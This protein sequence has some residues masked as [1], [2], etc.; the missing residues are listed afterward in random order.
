MNTFILSLFNNG[1][2]HMGL[3]TTNISLY[4]SPVFSVVCWPPP[5]DEAL[6]PYFEAALLTQQLPKKAPDPLAMHTL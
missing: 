4:H 1:M 2:V 3:E 5:V 6:N